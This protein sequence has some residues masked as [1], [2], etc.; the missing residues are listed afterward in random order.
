[1]KKVSPYEQELSN[2]FQKFQKK[3]EKKPFNFKA[4]INN[5]KQ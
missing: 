5:R 3:Q 4:L 2:T 1:M